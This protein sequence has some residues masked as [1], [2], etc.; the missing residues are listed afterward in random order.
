MIRG[1]KHKGH[2]S[3][4]NMYLQRGKEREGERKR[5][6]EEIGREER[7][8][9]GERERGR[10]RWGERKRER[11]EIGREE[12]GREVE[13]DGEREGERGEGGN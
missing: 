9:G 7:K 1:V 13:M 12:I 11:E 2:C 4:F 3:I 5:E 10:N 6:R 8:R